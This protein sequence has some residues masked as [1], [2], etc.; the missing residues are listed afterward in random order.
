MSGVPKLAILQYHS[1]MADSAQF[2]LGST[3]GVPRLIA[4][5]LHSSEALQCEVRDLQRD[6]GSGVT[7]FFLE[8]PL[9][10]EDA[11][12][13]AR[14]S[15]N[16]ATWCLHGD[17][18][19]EGERLVLR[20]RLLRLDQGEETSEAAHETCLEGDPGELGSMVYETA[21]EVLATIE[22]AGALGEGADPSLDREAAL[23]GLS[24]DGEAMKGYLSALA[25]SDFDERIALLTQAFE[26]DEGFV[27]AGV[28]L[29]QSLLY[30]REVQEAERFL[31]AATRRELISNQKLRA[32]AMEFFNRGMHAEATYLARK[33]M[34]WSPDEADAY[35]P[36][37]RIALV[38]GNIGDGL[39]YSQRAEKL[40]PSNPAFKAYL[41]LFYRYMQKF[42]QA[43]EYAQRAIEAGPDEAFH[44]YALG[45]AHLFGGNFRAAVRH[46]DK[47]LSLNPD[48]T[49]THREMAL[50]T[51]NL[52]E[53]GEARERMN[54]SL[55]RLPN[56][57][58][59]LTLRAQTFIA[60]DRFGEA[61]L[62]LERALRAE[63]NFPEAHGW[64]SQVLRE[65]DEIP[66][67]LEHVQ[68]AR[69]LD[70]SNTKWLIEQGH[71]FRAMGDEE[72]ARACYAQ[73]EGGG[74]GDDDL[75][76]DE[77]DD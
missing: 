21:T 58:F 8:S 42:D 69:Q 60:E 65:L 47:A 29:A 75:D 32:T 20:S 18:A 40:D 3:R 37:I 55:E 64:L 4:H 14:A 61:R 13:L 36:Y 26:R 57:P 25:S 77:D 41:S 59:L 74:G 68:K 56:D 24:S 76:F 35:V 16:G 39:K 38:T 5:M 70:P 9:G 28:E 31:V 52:Y 33:A 12:R 71:I 72:T 19:T 1:P 50:A 73:A 53:S 63:A 11:G 34:I 2:A 49:T 43:I 51:G 6:D 10:N 44:Y 46:F 67:A 45:S 62:D 30:N 15:T 66:K 54:T 27:D 22:M 17:L 23:E 48:D 7:A